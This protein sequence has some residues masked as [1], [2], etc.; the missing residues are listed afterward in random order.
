MSESTTEPM[1]TIN[2]VAERLSISRNTVYRLISKGH[3]RPVTVSERQRFSA[4]ELQ[5][6][7][8]RNTR[9]ARTVA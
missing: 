3:L 1:L 4:A 5:R 2:E 9:Q 7:I 6:Y 8:D